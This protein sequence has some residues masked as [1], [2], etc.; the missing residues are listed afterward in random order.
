MPAAAA[1]FDLD[2]VL[3]DSWQVAR[4]ALGEALAEVGYAG[5]PPYA[6]FRRRMG[7][8]LAT[9]LRELALPA[10][11]A[12]P[13][14]RTAMAMTDQVEM[15]AG[16]GEALAALRGAGFR[17]GVVTGKDRRRARAIVAAT[18]LDGMIDALVT[19]DDAPGKPD[20]A[21]CSL[22]CALLGT[23]RPLAYV[24]DSAVD[25]DTARAA[26][27]PAVLA[28]WGALPRTRDL[29]WNAIVERPGAITPELV[30]ALGSAAR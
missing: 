10:A 7:K 8:P 25:L 1:L 17:I 20:P 9:I 18:G 28:A 4:R 3:I 19:P 5:E 12:R 24:G 16:V 6:A 26:R 15:F 22:C 27:I 2:G 11:A 14:N 29:G 21:G 30:R 13:F 23:P